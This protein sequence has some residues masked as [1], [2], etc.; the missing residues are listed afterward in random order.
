MIDFAA[1]DSSP[2]QSWVF[3]AS[4]R[5]GMPAFDVYWGVIHAPISSMIA[6]LPPVKLLSPLVLPLLLKMPPERKFIW[7]TTLVS[8]VS[9]NSG[10]VRPGEGR[11]PWNFESG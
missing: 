8:E 5:A 7:S 1:G 10:V 3:R 2:A 11:R 4:T 6:P 9:W